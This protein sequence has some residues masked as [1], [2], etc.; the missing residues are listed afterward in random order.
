[1]ASPVHQT[2]HVER[3][4]LAG[5]ASESTSVLAAPVALTAM[6]TRAARITIAI[7]SRSRSSSFRKSTCSS[8]HAA[9]RIA[10]VLPAAMPA[11]ASGDGPIETLTRKAPRLTPGHIRR[12]QTS[13]PTKAIPVG[14]QIGDTCPRTRARRRLNRAVA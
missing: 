10:T 12:P 5:I 1:M 6:L 2:N 3:N 8:S 13:I 14:G 7:A 4:P 9:T 11:A